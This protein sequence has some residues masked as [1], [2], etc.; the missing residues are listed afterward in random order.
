MSYLNSNKAKEMYQ[1]LIAKGYDPKAAA[2]E[3]QAKTGISTATWQPIK[4]KSQQ[5]GSWDGEEEITFNGFGM[6]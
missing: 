1:D 3:T 6:T 2:K 4:S 5:L